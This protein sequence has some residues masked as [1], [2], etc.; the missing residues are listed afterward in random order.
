MRLLVIG[1]SSFL[2]RAVASEAL[3]RGHAVTTF[4]RGISSPDVPG[5]EALRGDREDAS[6]LEQLRGREFDA[7][8]DTYGY[9]PAVVRM[10]ASLLAGQVPAYAYVSS[11]SAMPQWPAERVDESMPAHECAPDADAD[12]GDYGVLKAGCERA[13]Q[14]AYGG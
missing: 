11:I 3:S 8:V 9:V 13:V 10:S 4:N 2:G 5:V 6:A 7:V 14:Q 1:G 12:A